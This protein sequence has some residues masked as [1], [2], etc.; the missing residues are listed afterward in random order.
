MTAQE[1]VGLRFQVIDT[2]IGM[3][4]ENVQRVFEPYFRVEGANAFRG[5]GL[6]LSIC[7]RLAQVLQA[8]L[9]AKSQLGVGTCMELELRVPVDPSSETDGMPQLLAAPVYVRGGFR[10]CGFDLCLAEALGAKALPYRADLPEQEGA[11]LLETWPPTQSIADWSGPRVLAQPLSQAV[12]QTSAA[13][14]WQV[15][16][17]SLLEMGRA[18]QMAQEA[19][20]QRADSAAAKQPGH[21]RTPMHLRV[22]VVEDHPVT[23]MILIEQLQQLGC[24]V[25]LC[26]TAKKPCNC[27]IS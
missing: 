13:N 25:G 2:G 4:A 8:R 7:A 15:S 24:E 6:G 11:V 1:Q 3:T 18:I 21:V 12:E 22:L 23:R 17:Y 16:A 26:R 5:T 20:L 14:T 9:N 19:G 10:C 27:R